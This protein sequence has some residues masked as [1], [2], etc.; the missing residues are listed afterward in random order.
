VALT[1]TVLSLHRW[2]VKSMAGEDVESLDLFAHGARGDRERGLYWRG[3]R[4]LTARAA[5]RMLAWSARSSG[6]GRGPVVTD[7]AGREWRWD[8][9][10]LQDA[11]S[12]DLGK[13][14]R[15][16][17]DPSLLLDL[18]DSLLITFDATHRGLERE[19]GSAIDLRRF[20][21]NVHVGMDVEPF[22]ETDWEGR[23][24][25]IGEA[26]LEF[27]HPCIRCVI[28]TRD[29]DTQEAWPQILRHLHNDR[30]SIFGINA[31][32]RNEATIRVGDPVAV[33]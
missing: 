10:G 20:R 13:E 28:V 4:R 30:G 21:T 18:A 16:V 3:G 31:R 15:L 6:D 9:D 26:E 14:V 12:G 27:L 17:E 29:P 25:R 8:D 19:L 24:L 32:P 11:I 5:P 1:G 33:I 2:P 7:P 22:A 23:T